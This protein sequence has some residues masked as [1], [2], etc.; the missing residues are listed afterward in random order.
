MLTG[1]WGVFSTYRCL[2]LKKIGFIEGRDCRYT[3]GPSLNLIALILRVL[4]WHLTRPQTT[5]QTGPT[6]V[7]SLRDD[8]CTRRQQGPFDARTSDV[9]IFWKRKVVYSP[10][11]SQVGDV[12]STCLAGDP[13]SNTR[14]SNCVNTP[15]GRSISAPSK[16]K[17]CC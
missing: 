3:G 2:I 8:P 9:D 4:R 6:T 11:A 16:T 13:S 1:N 12:T 17:I 10:V 5:S 15:V 7:F 14:G